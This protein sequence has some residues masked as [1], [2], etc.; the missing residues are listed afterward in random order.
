VRAVERGDTGDP[1]R[2]APDCA[3][4]AYAKRSHRNI[5]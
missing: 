3:T 5:V 4:N 2:V 1:G